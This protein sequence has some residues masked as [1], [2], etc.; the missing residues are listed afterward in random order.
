MLVG[1]GDVGA[2]VEQRLDRDVGPAPH[3]AQQ[4]RGAVLVGRI[5][6]GAEVDQPADG[7][8][9]IAFAVVFAVDDRIGGVVQRRRRP[10]VAALVDQAGE[11]AAAA[12]AVEPVRRRQ[13]VQEVV[14]AIEPVQEGARAEHVLLD[15]QARHLLD[16]DGRAAPDPHAGGQPARPMASSRFMVGHPAARWRPLP[17]RRRPLAAPAA[18]SRY[19]SGSMAIAP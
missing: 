19:R 10:A 1:D 7:L 3:R 15:A 16:D 8:F 4:R 5:D 11:V 17:S 6:L 18:I 14:A 13:D 12:E 2:A 9:L